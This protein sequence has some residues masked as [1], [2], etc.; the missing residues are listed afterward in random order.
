MR[1]GEGF[2]EALVPLESADDGGAA[3]A[4]ASDQT[5]EPLGLEPAEV[6][7]GDHVVGTHIEADATGATAVPG[8]WVAGNLTDVQAQVISSAAAGPCSS[9]RSGGAAD[10][11]RDSAAGSGTGS[12]ARVTAHAVSIAS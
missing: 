7:I 4:L 5:R 3:I 2:G 9:S 6:R 10:S 11:H 1:V 8:V 12:S